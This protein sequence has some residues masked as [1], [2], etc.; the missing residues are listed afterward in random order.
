MEPIYWLTRQREE[1][2]LASGAASAEARLAHHELAARYGDKARRVEAEALA[3]WGI[4][5]VPSDQY[6]VDGFCYTN[7]GDV[8]AE[9]PRGTTL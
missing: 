5:G 3:C 9:P 1:A 4:A 6:W 7:P 2:E 8:I